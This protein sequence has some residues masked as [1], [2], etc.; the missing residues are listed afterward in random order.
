MIARFVWFAFLVLALMLVGTDLFGHMLSA[1]EHRFCVLWA[2][3]W[4]VVSLLR[5]TLMGLLSALAA[6][7]TGAARRRSG[8]TSAAT[9]DNGRDAPFPVGGPRHAQGREKWVH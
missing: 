1:G 4:P 3:L 7:I 6:S 2:C 9:P 8:G 5:G